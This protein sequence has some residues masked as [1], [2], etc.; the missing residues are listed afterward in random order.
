VIAL[1]AKIKSSPEDFVVDEMLA[2]GRL[3][4]ECTGFNESAGAFIW[5]ALK[6]INWNTID[7][8]REIAHSVHVSE[9]QV[10]YGGIKDRTAVAYQVFSINTREK[11]E[12]V[13]EKIGRIRDVEVLGA[14]RNN[15]W[16]KGEDFVGNRFEI[17]LR[18]CNFRARDVKKIDK[19]PNYFG[20]Q[21]FGSMHGNSHIVGFHLLK[22]D[23]DSAIREY[24]A[25][26][27]C[28]E[29]GTGREREMYEK[30]KRYGPQ[31]FVKHYWRVF[32]L[33]LNAAQSHLFNEELE[34]RI[35]D[36]ELGPLEGEYTCGRNRFGFADVNVEGAEFTV[37]PLVGSECKILNKYKQMLMKKYGVESED[38]R[39]AELKGGWRTLFAPIVDLKVE[40]VESKN[41]VK[42][43]FKLQKGAYATTAVKELLKK[44]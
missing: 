9:K 29:F 39:K 3:A 35:A 33:C 26:N 2:D 6:K 23:Y 16:I 7:L 38:F 4:S 37:V 44:V 43:S 12:N 28:C 21:R 24:F 11:I 22:G 25:E 34:M 1:E 30:S 15:R 10:N 36:R 19:F 42:L 41:A 14:W 27:E 17:I 8:A 20:E 13:K 32:K 40:D 31:M 5:V 18:E